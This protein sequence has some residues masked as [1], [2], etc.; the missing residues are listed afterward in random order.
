[1]LSVILGGEIL[2][3]QSAPLAKRGRGGAGGPEEA[4]EEA[5]CLAE[6]PAWTARRVTRHEKLAAPRQ[7][8]AGFMS[9]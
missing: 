9:T 2:A 3:E 7:I 6:G 8:G 1:M 4:T 5:R